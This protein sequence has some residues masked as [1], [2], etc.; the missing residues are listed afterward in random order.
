[1]VLNYFRKEEVD[2][3]RTLLSFGVEYSND[4]RPIWQRF[5]QLARI[6]RSDESLNEYFNGFM[7]MIKKQLGMSTSDDEGNENNF[8]ILTR[9]RNMFEP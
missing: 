8:S 6:D 2:F 9:I 3:Y 7:T 4:R 5:K 1:M